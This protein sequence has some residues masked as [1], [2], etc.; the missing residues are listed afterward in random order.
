MHQFGANQYLNIVLALGNFISK[1]VKLSRSR[2]SSS[3]A[4]TSVL[5]SRLM[6]GFDEIAMILPNKLSRFK[7]W[8]FTH[9]ICVYNMLTKSDEILLNKPSSAV[10]NVLHLLEDYLRNYGM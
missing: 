2:D 4:I 9:I 7:D 10:I 5:Y 8:Q 6:D 1:E 3:T